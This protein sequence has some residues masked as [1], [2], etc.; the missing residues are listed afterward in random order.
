MRRLRVMPRCARP[1]ASCDACSPGAP[2]TLEEARA[3]LAEGDILLGGGDASAWPGLGA[4][5]DEARRR[6][7]PPRVWVEAPAASLSRERL[8]ALAA[9]GVH[10][11]LVQIEGVGA[12]LLRAMRAG[13]G[14]RAIAEAEEE[15]LATRAR[16]IARPATFPMV[17]PLAARLSPRPVWLELVRR[18]WG[19]PEV[20]IHPGPLSRLLLACANIDFSGHRTARRGYL[21]PCLLPDVWRARPAAFRTTLREG[22]GA[23]NATLPACAE[24]ALRT[25]CQ[26]DDRGALREEDASAAQPIRDP[27]LPWE[28]SRAVHRE[29]PS[30]ITKKRR[31]PEVICT[32]PWTTMEIVDPDGL[33]RQCC[34]TWTIGARGNVHEATL[35]EVWNGPGYRAARARMAAAELGEL[36]NPICSPLH[37]RR[38]AESRFRI[39]EGSPRFVRNQLLIAEDIAERR[40]LVRGK[41]LWLAVCPSTY[42]NFDCIMCNH[43]RSPRRELPDAIWEELPE[44]LPTLQTLT[45]LGGEPLASPAVMKLLRDFD[46]AKYPDCTIDLVT[47]GSLLTEAVLAR[48]ER[49]TLGDVTISLNAGTPE[50]F[51]R[52]QRGCAMSTVLENLDALLRF[53]ARHHR[54]FGVT[55]SFVVQPASAHTL[56]AFGEIARSRDLRIRLLA[57]NPEHDPE[58]LDFYRDPDAV[59]N[60]LREVDAFAAWARA[61]RPEWLEEI[62]AVRAAVAGEAAARA[63][64]KPHARR[65]PVVARG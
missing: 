15:G 5:L 11:V 65:L 28:R 12:K 8:R 51:E 54:W 10:G 2:A 31:G 18:D 17:A 16:V 24:C 9:R 63:A 49:C 34:T 32:T 7:K 27:V 53:R 22:G 64:G 14:E 39:R 60:V 20:P 44:L 59:A 23:P 19:K 52:V 46:V 26:F 48:M 43:G 36:C 38:Y 37:D 4:F 45:L 30:V 50:V 6:P 35:M 3:A 33:V 42:C 40:E 1:C 41:P 56:I 55:L 62:R 57:V 29:V 58:T 21:P 13:D 61:R 47:N 25:R